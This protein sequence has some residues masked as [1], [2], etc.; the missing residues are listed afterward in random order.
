MLVQHNINIY[1]R[2][3]FTRFPNMHFHFWIGTGSKR[4]TTNMHKAL[5]RIAWCN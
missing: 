3:L 1:K 4:S 2:M 5:T